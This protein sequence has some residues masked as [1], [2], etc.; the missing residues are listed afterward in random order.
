MDCTTNSKLVYC[1]SY[2]II[3]DWKN[4]EE[5]RE[6]LNAFVVGKYKYDH[7]P[8]IL[9]CTHGMDG[10]ITSSEYMG[11]G[12]M[13]RIEYTNMIP[14]PESIMFFPIV[15]MLKQLCQDYNFKFNIMNRSCVNW[16]Y[17]NQNK[18]DLFSNWHT[19]HEYPHT[20]VIWYL[21]DVDGDTLLNINNEIVNVTPKKDRILVFDGLIPHNV[22]RPKTDMRKVLITTFT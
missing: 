3:D 14:K 2:L 11:H 17:P 8:F 12:V 5:H 18:D 10:I 1:M 13:Q 15:N 16:T 7:L 9:N 22:I 4:I 20:Q 21:N 6:T 19:D